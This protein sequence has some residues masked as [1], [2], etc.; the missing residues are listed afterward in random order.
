MTPLG[1]HRYPSRLFQYQTNFCFLCGDI[2]VFLLISNVFRLYQ[3]EAIAMEV[4]LWCFLKLLGYFPFYTQ[5]LR[6][7]ED[8]ICFLV[9]HLVGLTTIME[10]IRCLLLR[11]TRIFTFIS[12][13]FFIFG[14]IHSV[15]YFA[16]CSGFEV[17]INVYVR[18]LIMPSAW[19]VSA[20]WIRTCGFMC[21][22]LRKMPT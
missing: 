11:W 7:E 12:V 2:W 17:S 6:Q 19:I 1:R 15:D 22:S 9:L 14:P 5:I 8:T 21:L 13:F 16:L 3:W 18:V 10:L 4:V 20:H